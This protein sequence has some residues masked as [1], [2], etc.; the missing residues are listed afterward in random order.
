MALGESWSVIRNK[1]SKEKLIRSN[2]SDTISEG[3]RFSYGNLYD[4]QVAYSSKMLLLL[5]WL[6][7]AVRDVVM[8]DVVTVCYVIKLKY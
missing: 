1:K 2:S 4:R 3:D 6:L 8:G 7:Y 5:C